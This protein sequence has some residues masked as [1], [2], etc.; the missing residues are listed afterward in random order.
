M[1]RCEKLTKR[2]GRT[3]ALDAL[4]LS[5]GDGELHGFIGPNGAGKTTTMKILATLMRPTSGTACVDGVDVCADQKRART[6]VGYMPDFFGVYDNLKAW[7]YLDFY[8]G[9]AGMEARARRKRIDELLDLMALSAKREAYVDGLSRGMKQRLCLARAMMHDPKLLILDEPASG[10]DPRARAEMRDILREIGRMGKTVLISSHILP[11]LS[12]LCTSMTI[13]DKGRT[14]FSGPMAD[15]ERRMHSAPLAVRF[16]CA[17]DDALADKAAAGIRAQF[18]AA[19]Q[20]E[21]PCLWRLDT[22]ASPEQDAALLRLMV[23]QGLPVCGFTREHTS[24]E[25]VFME[26]TNAYD[27]ESDL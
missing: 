22:P 6:L 25:K 12:E 9:C 26:V 23:E 15:L 1:I 13:L 19:P 17:P 20:R 24:L 21:E 3:L 8:A 10:M 18:G 4:D 7:E 16:G 2:Y 14:V 5:V 11:E 27:A